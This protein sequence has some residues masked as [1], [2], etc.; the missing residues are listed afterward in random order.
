MLI[1]N[2]TCQKIPY[3]LI[4]LMLYNRILWMLLFFLSNSLEICM[5]KL[6]A[7]KFSYNSFECQN[8][9]SSK[10]IPTSLTYFSLIFYIYFCWFFCVHFTSAYIFF[11]LVMEELAVQFGTLFTLWSST[12]ILRL[13]LHWI[14]QEWKETRSNY[15]V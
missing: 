6:I 4:P 5:T 14:L 1:A 12:F 3:D 13:L 2:F 10:L 8:I 15:E 9:F 7:I 11:P